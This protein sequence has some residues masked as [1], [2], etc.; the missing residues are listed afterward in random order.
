[1]VR[2]KHSLF[3]VGD[4]KQSIYGWRGGESAFLD[5]LPTSCGPSRVEF[6][7]VPP[8][9]D[10]ET[11]LKSWRSGQ[12]VIDAVNKV[13][14]SIAS[15]AAVVGASKDAAAS[16]GQWFET[17]S[18]EKTKLGGKA[19]LEI[20]PEPVEGEHA[21]EVMA[22]EAAR[23]AKE[24]RRTAARGSVAVL[25]RRNKAVGMIVEELRKLDVPAAGQGRWFA[26]RY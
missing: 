15:N 5:K 22:R 9:K 23:A 2:A 4:L 13:F 18:T 8:S 21:D 26:H 6:R 11:L 7:I 25:V 17:H 3:V 10:G 12:P 20:L 1:M 24:L 19:M 16:F 14:E